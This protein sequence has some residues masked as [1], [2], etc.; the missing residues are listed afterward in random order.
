MAFNVCSKLLETYD[1]NCLCGSD[2]M[3]QKMFNTKHEN[4]G[5]TILT[6]LIKNHYNAKKPIAKY[7]SG[8]FSMT[9]LWSQKYKKRIYVVGE[10]HG[11]EDSCDTDYTNIADYYLELFKNTDVLID[12]YLET[13]QTEEKTDTPEYYIAIIR[14]LVDKCIDR[15]NDKKCELIRAHFVDVRQQERDQI[16][17]YNEYMLL[18]LGILDKDPSPE[19]LKIV[20]QKLVGLISVLKKLD[21]QTIYRLLF[22]QGYNR[23]EIGRSYMKNEILEY[24]T[25]ILK[26]TVANFHEE[27]AVLDSAEEINYELLE[28]VYVSLIKVQALQLDVYGLSRIF[29]KFKKTELEYPDEAHNIIYHVGEAHAEFVRGFLSHIGFETLASAQIYDDKQRC[30]DMKNIEQ[31]L[32]SKCVLGNNS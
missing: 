18:L 24:T 30:L 10:H 9:E 29:K 28:E 21:Y 12:F 25:P 26:Q 23:K 27:L 31:P 15:K 8:P 20:E 11:V 17:Q 22:T 6:Q 19:H 5:R 3:I 16:V 2:E 14:D 13:Y 4:A 32:F 1:T 7:I